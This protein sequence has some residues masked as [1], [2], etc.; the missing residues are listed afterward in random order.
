MIVVIFAAVGSG[1]VVLVATWSSF[2]LSALLLAS[3]I[4][5]ATG[6]LTGLFLAV[7][8]RDKSFPT[9]VR[10]EVS[11]AAVPPRTTVCPIK[12]RAEV[13]PLAR[14]ALKKLV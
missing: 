11:V 2:G 4:A 13:G 8:R 5:S 3:A 7:H 9:A 10:T 12:R 6:L 14:S 1:L